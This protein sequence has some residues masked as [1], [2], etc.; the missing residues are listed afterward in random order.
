MSALVYKHSFFIAYAKINFNTKMSKID[1]NL[2]VP[3]SRSLND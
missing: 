1:Y 3:I 2:D